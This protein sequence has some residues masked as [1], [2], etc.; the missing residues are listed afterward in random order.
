MAMVIIDDSNTRVDPRA[1]MASP[2]LRSFL[3]VDKRWCRRCG[4]AIA[5]DRARTARYCSDRCR[6]DAWN[7]RTRG[8]APD[9]EDTEAGRLEVRRRLAAASRVERRCKC[10]NPLGLVDQDGQAACFRCG[11]P[12]ARDRVGELPPAA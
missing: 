7:E 12:L 10:S 4:T 11:W 2:R 8:T 3:T 6:R 5:A 1:T 9:D